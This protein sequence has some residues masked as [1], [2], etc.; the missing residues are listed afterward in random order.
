MIDIITYCD[1]HQKILRDLFFKPS[2]N[3]FLKQSFNHIDIFYDSDTNS[4]NDL[5]FGSQIFQDMIFHRW[6][7]LINHVESCIDK[8]KVSVFSDIDIL[9]LGDFSHNIK[10]MME[11]K[12]RNIAMS[13]NIDIFFMPETPSRSNYQMRNNHNI[14]AGFFIFRHS[15]ATLHFFNFVLDFMK[16]QKIK[17]DQFYIRKYLKNN[18]QSNIGLL[19]FNVFNT[20]NCGLDVNESLIKNNTLKVFHATSCYDIYE[21]IRVLTSLSTKIAKPLI[22]KIYE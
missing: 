17:E 3:L 19:D 13:T 9:F 14:N 10:Y 20:N 5:G 4:A 11:S 21:K 7:I 22:Q 12:P 1:N 16:K 2:F 18:F 6:E 15:K 8:N